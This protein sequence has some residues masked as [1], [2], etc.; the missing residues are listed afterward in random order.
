MIEGEQAIEAMEVFE[1][2]EAI[3]RIKDT[4]YRHSK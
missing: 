4:L 1:R 2:M 3:E